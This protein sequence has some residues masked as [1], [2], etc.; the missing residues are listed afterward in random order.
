M[1]SLCGGQL[2][3]G[4]YLSTKNEWTFIDVSK[5]NDSEKSR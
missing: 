2:G 4:E 3:F 5:Q 1:L